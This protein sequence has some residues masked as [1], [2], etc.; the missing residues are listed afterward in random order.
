MANIVILGYGKMGHAIENV[1][2]ARNLPDIHILNSYEEMQ[3]FEFPND[4]VVIEFTRA[5]SCLDNYKYL[6]EQSI[7]V[8][9]GTTGWL[10]HEQ[11]IKSL[12]K[13]NNGKFLYAANFSIGVHLFWHLI[14]KAGQLFN[15]QDQYDVYGHE[16]HHPHKADSP[17]GTAVHT[18]QILLD[19]IKR[20]TKLVSGDVEGPVPEE[21]LHFS[22]TRGGYQFGEHSVM[23]DGPDDLITIQHHAKSRDGFANGAVDCALWLLHQEADGYFTI[24]DYLKDI[25]K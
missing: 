24:N 22:A 3:S 19:N 16:F 18:A 8:V 7:P 17:S 1:C 12:V 9:T 13:E 2:N 5:P 20:K 11:D 14:E 23:F 15:S 6:M 25:L 21:H 4:C 10:E